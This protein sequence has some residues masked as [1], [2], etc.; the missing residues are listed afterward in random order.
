[1]DLKIG[2]MLVSNREQENWRNGMLHSVCFVSFN[3]TNNIFS[4]VII[5]IITIQ[6]YGNYDKINKNIYEFQN[7]LRI[8]EEFE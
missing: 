7:D 2:G 3:I 5:I 8:I 6:Q 4:I 1:M